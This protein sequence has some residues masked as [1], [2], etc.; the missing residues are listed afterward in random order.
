MRK[1]PYSILFFALLLFASC[2]DFKHLSNRG[3]LMV[4]TKQDLFRGLNFDVTLQDVKQAEAISPELEYPDNMRYHIVADSIAEGESLDVEYF[5]NKK[6][7]LDLMIAFYNISDSNAIHP[8]VNE[9]MRYL[10]REH[11]R[12]KQDELGWYHWEFQD[13]KGEPGSIE[14]N[15]VGETEAGYMGVEVEMIKYYA[16]EEKMSNSR[17]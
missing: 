16:Y 14:I 6:N 1:I 10:E 11:G 17:K 3:K 4:K 15:L 13:K 12:P 9:L 7:Q 2:N 5:F 8:I